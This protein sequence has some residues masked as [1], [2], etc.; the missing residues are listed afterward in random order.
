MFRNIKNIIKIFALL[1]L[2]ISF[3]LPE[4]DVAAEDNIKV[5][6]AKQGVVNIQV[7]IVN[8]DDFLLLRQ[9][10]GFL[11]SNLDDSVNIV[12]TNHIVSIPQKRLKKICK[13][14]NIN[15]DYGDV[16]L[17]YR[18]IVDGDVT[19][20]VS[21]MA[22]SEETDFC[23]LETSN[24]IKERVPIKINMED[25]C[26][27]GSQVFSLGYSYD[28]AESGDYSANSV[29]IS[30]G[31][32][33][34][35]E[36]KVNGNYYI[37]HTAFVDMYNSGG[38]LV[39]E[40][41][42]VVG[43]LDNVEDD[44]YY[45]IPMSQIKIILDNYGIYYDSKDK[46]MKKEE[47]DVILKECEKLSGEK[48]YT[49]ESQTLFKEN[50]DKVKSEI[51]NKST[52]TLEETENYILTLDNA[53]KALKKKTSKLVYLYYCLI[54]LLAYLL[55]RVIVLLV[56]YLKLRKLVNGEGETRDKD[57]IGL[58]SNVVDKKIAGA[59][60]NP[61]SSAGNGT[62]GNVNRTGNNLSQFHSAT[63]VN[64]ENQYR[65]SG[66]GNNVNQANK[67]DRNAIIDESESDKTIKLYD[68]TSS[69]NFDAKLIRSANSQVIIINQNPFIIGK[70][71]GQV[72]YCIGDNASISR[73]HAKIE[74]VNG[75][76]FIYDLGSVNGTFVDGA[77]EK[78]QGKELK[79][80]TVIL[81]S[82]EKFVFEFENLK[83][84]EG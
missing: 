38:V 17:S 4:K 68:D 77:E 61:V 28:D 69:P 41:G 14:N 8:K 15:T 84:K 31:T 76:Y 78:G 30:S 70:K 11:I 57:V 10:S 32:I 79:N 73:V 49:N 45:A 40:Q 59:N 12:T 18:L 16:Q 46:D 67:P 39:D 13:N 47:L 53:K 56:K 65:Q 71:I 2:T 64:N 35:V 51:D 58:S 27:A 63:S 62:N 7:G 22:Q 36:S 33:E 1:M 43:M 54:A 25:T 34:D 48:G 50:Y 26:Q 20:E 60:Q 75:K 72:N 24:V 55:I 80:G 37:K 81:L 5:E 82:N 21:I 6:D 9:G 52:F 19:T 74:K 66:F 23:I 83:A 44:S 42:Y 3:M 29:E